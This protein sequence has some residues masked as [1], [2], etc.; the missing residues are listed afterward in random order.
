MKPT[1]IAKNTK[2]L[3]KLI[4]EEIELNGNE[5]ELNHIDVSQ[6]TDMASL[7]SN[8]EFNGDISKWDTSN[9]E[10]M[11]FM[12]M[13]SK[14]N[15]DISDWDVSKVIDMFALFTQSDFTGNLNK[16][17]PIGLE[18]NTQMFSNTKC[19]PAY[20]SVYEDKESRQKAINAY[21]LNEELSNT[22]SEKKLIVK[23]LKI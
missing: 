6:L 20:W 22:L 21:Q 2:H 15:N 18:L 13:N 11:S 3:E 9:V 1:I 12:F 5:C 4:K 16:W 10:D 19:E 23:K 8:S 14:F 7:F 17:K